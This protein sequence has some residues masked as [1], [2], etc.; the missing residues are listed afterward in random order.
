[1][2]DMTKEETPL[3]T[4]RKIHESIENELIQ[5]AGFDEHHGLLPSS[6]NIEKILSQ[7]TQKQVAAKLARIIK[8][9]NR[10]ETVINHCE[11][12][13]IHDDGDGKCGNV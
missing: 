9:V 12:F 6:P 13:G 10:M 2:S 3:V 1:M 7:M 4:I 5:I 11:Y 8:L